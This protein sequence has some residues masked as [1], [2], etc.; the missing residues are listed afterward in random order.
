MMP[1]DGRSWHRPWN[2]VFV[3]GLLFTL[4]PEQVRRFCDIHGIS[5]VINMRLPTWQDSGSGRLRGFE[6]VIFD[7]EGLRARTLGHDVNGKELGVRDVTI[8]EANAPRA[9][10]T[11][12]CA[13][14]GHAGGGMRR[15]INQ[16][17]AEL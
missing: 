13:V 17:G 15:G 8:R 7:S 16:G 12:W 4:T 2:T 10:T 5:D 14:C 6:H 3:K 9:G 1:S 11:M